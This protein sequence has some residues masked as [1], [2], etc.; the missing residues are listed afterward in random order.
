[1]FRWISNSFFNLLLVQSRPQETTIVKCRIQDR[2]DVTSLRVEPRSR[3]QGRR[4]NDV[5]SLLATLPT[6]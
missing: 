5:F 3:D 1:M 2:N 4:K 6:F